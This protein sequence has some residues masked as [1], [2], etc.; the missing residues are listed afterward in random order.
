MKAI[1]LVI[2]RCRVFI[3]KKFGVPENTCL[4][5]FFGKGKAERKAIQIAISIAILSNSDGFDA[6]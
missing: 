6:V 3:L 1:Y 2:L 4:Q 5:E